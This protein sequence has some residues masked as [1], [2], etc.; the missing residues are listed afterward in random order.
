M[1]SDGVWYVVCGVQAMRK[2]NAEGARIYASVRF[3]ARG[4]ADRTGGGNPW[5][6]D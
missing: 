6:H 2:G 4:T 5:T 1:V 3:A